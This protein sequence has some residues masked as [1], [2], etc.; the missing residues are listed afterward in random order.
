MSFNA[1]FMGWNR[2]IPGREAAAGEL[3]GDFLQYLG[4]LQGAG[5][6]DSFEPVLL[7][8][9][10]GDLNGFVLIRGPVDNLNAML[11]SPEWASFNTR[12]SLLLDG[13]G[14]V[15]AAIGDLIMEWM[16]AWTENIPG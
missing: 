11:S 6:I 5:Q 10:G 2:A 7:T 4:G 12:G 1:V 8:P 14:A 15:T 13:P 9:H 3:F 16:K